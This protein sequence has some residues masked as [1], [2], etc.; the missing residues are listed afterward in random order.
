MA[1]R[2]RARRIGF[3]RFLADLAY[4]L[5]G[6]VYSPVALHHILITGKHRSG[7]SQRFG[8]V[9]QRDPATKRVWIHAV[10]LGE[11]N[12][13]PK[14]VDGL[15]RELPDHEF[16]FSTTTDTGYARAVA[17]YG[18]ER[19]FRFP[20]DF[21]WVIRRALARVRPSAIVLMELEVWYNLTRMATR[22]GIPV[23]I[24]NGRLTERS[25]RRFSLI[26]GLVRPMFADLAWVG[27]QDEP[28]AARFRAVGV[29]ADRVAVT[30]SLKWDT[31]VVADRIAG[32]DSMAAALGIGPYERLWV[33]G[34]TGPGEEGM[35]LDAYSRLLNSEREQPR[36]SRREIDRTR[37][38]RSNEGGGVPVD[39]A[40]AE[41]AVANADHPVASLGHTATE[42]AARDLQQ[43]EGCGAAPRVRLAI[44]P[45]KPERFDEV[46]RWIAERGFACLRRSE[47]PDAA[48]PVRNQLAIEPGESRAQRCSPSTDVRP[49]VIL[50]DTM[51]ELRKF[52]SLASVVFV[53]R[54]LV[55][56][57][58][59]DVMEV[60]ALGKPILVGPHTDN[61][62]EAVESLRRAN[63]ALFVDSAQSLS[64]GVGRLLR[65]QTARA[66]FG[67]RAREVV[68]LSQGATERTVRGIVSVLRGTT[69]AAR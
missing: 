26:A 33:C 38:S 34:S 15:Q 17:L 14:L 31:A 21:S 51:G 25:A 52:Y 10:S 1:A 18:P 49:A 45:R 23:L 48:D 5:A 44:V 32:D 16:V 36:I 20:L 62:R 56:M 43:S 67:E 8:A 58:G 54:S 63:A 55:P 22:R 39:R 12:A 40:N 53:G 37:P 13:T 27:A 65:D 64:E 30:S 69:V 61:F 19:V 42:D 11:I 29:H 28:T 46:A 35:I 3:M 6:I 9:P 57:G 2:G 4:L 60:A 59:S 24:A 66:G 41:L 68:R 50:G 7:W 47:H